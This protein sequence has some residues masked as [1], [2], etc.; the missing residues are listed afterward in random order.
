MHK[1]DIVEYGGKDVNILS[2]KKGRRGKVTKK[3]GK[4]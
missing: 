1:V 2:G 3:R 4:K